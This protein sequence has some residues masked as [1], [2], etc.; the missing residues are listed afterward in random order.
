MFIF[1]YLIFFVLPRAKVQFI[2]V[3]YKI[4]DD[5]VGISRLFMLILQFEKK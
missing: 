5:F 3:K 2:F 4:L 1:C